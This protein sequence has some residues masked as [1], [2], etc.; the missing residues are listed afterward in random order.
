MQWKSLKAKSKMLESVV[1][2]KTVEH[3]V[4]CYCGAGSPC[5]ELACP[6]LCT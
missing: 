5:L 2:Q 1:A 6:P 3:A 4:V